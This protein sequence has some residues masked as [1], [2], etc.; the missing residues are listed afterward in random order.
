MPDDRHIVHDSEEQRHHHAFSQWCRSRAEENPWTD[1]EKADLRRDD[2]IERLRRSLTRELSYIDSRIEHAQNTIDQLRSPHIYDV[3]FEG[4]SDTETLL[5]DARRAIA[6]A[7]RTNP[8]QAAD[9]A[10]ESYAIRQRMAAIAARITPCPRPDDTATPCEHNEPWP[11]TWTQ[12]AWMARGW[13]PDQE[14]WRAAPE[15]I[16]PF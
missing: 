14:T 11:C 3:E 6:K 15:N 7:I 5:A 2:E 10:T 12:T 9:E 8:A 1:D 13:D 4:G 16:A